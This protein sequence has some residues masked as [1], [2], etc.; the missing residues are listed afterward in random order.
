MPTMGETIF[1]QGDQS[2]VTGM[3]IDQW[4]MQSFNSEN[5]TAYF[6][7][8][9]S[10][11]ILSGNKLTGSIQNQ[12]ELAVRD[13]VVV[14]GNS[15]IQLGDLSPQESKVI[16]HTITDQPSDLYGGMLTHRILENLYP[17]GGFEY[18]R[19]YE[20]RRSV[21]DAT[22]QPIGF[23]TGPTFETS[24]TSQEDTLYLSS[25]YFLGWV[26]ESPPEIK[27]NGKQAAQNTL[28]LLTTHLP[29]QLASGDYYIPTTL[30]Q[31]RQ[32]N[33]TPNSGY[34]GG[35]STYVFLD[36]GSAEFEFNIPPALL[37]TTPD[38]L[39]VEYQEEVSQWNG[40]DT[41]SMSLSIFDWEKYL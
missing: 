3:D 11:I 23:W 21:L 8:I 4:S 26:E 36:Y 37:D 9:K 30:I 32:T 40:A 17:T 29:F 31:G 12:M 2:K 25:V 20:L 22:F 24:A 1:L 15:V 34:C 14:F 16:E 39:L 19:D 27:V 6:G 28:G 35:G 38:H 13:A 5:M 18:Q 33:Q 41:A 7:Q 10:Q